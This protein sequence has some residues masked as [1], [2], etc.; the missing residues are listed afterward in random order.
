MWIDAFDDDSF[1]D[2]MKTGIESRTKY[3]FIEFCHF[4]DLEPPSNLSFKNNFND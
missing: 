3:L 2:E 1:D 4:E